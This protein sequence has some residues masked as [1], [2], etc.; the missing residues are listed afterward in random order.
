MTSYPNWFWYPSTSAPPEWVEQIADVFHN[1][2]ENI[3]SVEIQGL[4]SDGVL[5]EITDGLE[6][7]GFEIETGKNK[8]EKILRPVLFGE[9]GIPRV[10]YEV[11]G[12]HDELGIVLEVEAGRGWMGNALYRDLIRTSLIVNAQYLVLGMMNEYRYGN[13]AT[14]RSYDQAKDQLDAIYA[15]GRLQLPFEGILLIG[16]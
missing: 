6:Q 16:Y 5:A 15:S 13:N 14:N 11:D 8:K 10:T 9:N 2:Q 12:V 3:D 4:K 7:I 1:S